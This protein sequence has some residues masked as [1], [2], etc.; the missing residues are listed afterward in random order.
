MILPGNLTPYL[1]TISLTDGR[2]NGGRGSPLKPDFSVN[3]RKRPQLRPSKF[4]VS[5]GSLI[6]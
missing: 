2:V 6:L 5:S 4:T 3:T 1:R